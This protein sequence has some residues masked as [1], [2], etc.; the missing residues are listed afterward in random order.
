MH[1]PPLKAPGSGVFVIACDPDPEPW[2]DKSQPFM[3]IV[4]APEYA[5]EIRQKLATEKP[6]HLYSVIPCAASTIHYQPL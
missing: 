2:E 5:E 4:G 3:V 1:G 6:A